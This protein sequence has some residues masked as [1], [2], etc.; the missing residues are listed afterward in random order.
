MT[1]PCF[2]LVASEI[3]VPPAY[4][5]VSESL[6]EGSSCRH[7]WISEKSP[8]FLLKCVEKAEV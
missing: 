3:K 5:T 8:E 2:G 1:K 6:N 4:E 7:V